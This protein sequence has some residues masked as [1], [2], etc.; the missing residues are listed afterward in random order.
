MQF[1]AVAAAVNAVTQ[2]GNRTSVDD[3]D[4]AAVDA[5]YSDCTPTMPT[6]RA[7]RLPTQTRAVAR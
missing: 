2:L 4:V 3:F 7:I 6:T 1:T 5:L